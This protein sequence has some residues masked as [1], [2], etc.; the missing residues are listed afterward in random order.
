MSACLSI[1]LDLKKNA[2]EG[3]AQHQEGCA[4]A[5]SCYSLFPGLGEPL[6]W[7]PPW[8]SPWLQARAEPGKGISKVA[9]KGQV[10]V[11]SE[12][13]NAHLPTSAEGE[14]LPTTAGGMG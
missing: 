9:S 8:A 2:G 10:G 1:R 12:D 3:L 14:R 11:G 7:H 4:L 13:Q 5:G 6:I